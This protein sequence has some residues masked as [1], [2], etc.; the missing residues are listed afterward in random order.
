MRIWR[1]VYLATFFASTISWPA[2]AQQPPNT[3]PPGNPYAI[4]INDHAKGTDIGAQI[5][6]THNASPGTGAT[7]EIPAGS[8]TYSTPI[9]ITKPVRLIGAGKAATILKF[10]ST[11]SDAITIN[12]THDSV[13]AS[14]PSLEDFSL[15]GPGAGSGNGITIKSA[16]EL[17]GKNIFV[18]AFGGDGWHIAATGGRVNADGAVLVSCESH[19]NGGHGFFISPLGGDSNLISIIGGAAYLNTQD[20]YFIDGSWVYLLNPDGSYN[21]RY[22]FNF[23]LA[24]DARGTVYA[25][26]NLTGNV[27][28][29][30]SSQNNVIDIQPSG[31]APT[32]TGKHNSYRGRYATG[33]G[34]PLVAVNIALSAGW[35]A[36]AAV[37]QVSGTDDAFSFLV[38]AAGPNQAPSPTIAIT[39]KDGAWPSPPVCLQ[40]MVGG[41][42]TWAATA[43]KNVTST[44]LTLLWWGTPIAGNSYRFNVVC[45]GN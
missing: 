36:A 5:N 19:N 3:V 43:Q 20:G 31:G 34:T 39:F 24:H 12:V 28:F 21:K 40:E 7:I 44:V 23:N 8:F 27:N 4:R 15:I 38:T 25:E 32:D 6:T 45:Q 2:V 22:G 13:V 11:T 37:S 29:G 10:T 42:G 14:T 26:L 1:L 9:V 41:S 18:R 16:Y 33:R 17:F 35:G 30:P